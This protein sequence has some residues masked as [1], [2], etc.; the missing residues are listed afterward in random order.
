MASLD[1]TLWP[2]YTI[3]RLRSGSALVQVM[4]CRL[5]T[6]SKPL[7]VARFCDIHPKGI[8][9]R[10]PNLFSSIMEIILLKLLPHLPGAYEVTSM[11]SNKMTW[12]TAKMCGSIS[13]LPWLATT[14]IDFT[15]I[16]MTSSNGNIFRVTGP[17]CGEFTSH[18]WI[19]LTKASDAELWCF[20]DLRLE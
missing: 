17:L 5:P 8:S 15:E 11:P 9:Q 18:W 13:M 20:F 6:P 19:P 12:T 16:M 2:C 10:V 3:R 7:S 14:L 4:A 1:H